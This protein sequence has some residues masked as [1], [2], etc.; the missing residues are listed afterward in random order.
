MS[1]AE[2]QRFAAAVQA[3]PA[4]AEAYRAA[5]TPVELAARLRADGYVVTDA[6]VEEVHRSGAELSDEQLDDVSGGV[7]AAALASI[8]GIGAIGVL[9]G[10]IIGIV[11]A[12]AKRGT[13]P[14]G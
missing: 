13:L 5:A 7:V 12:A 3:T 10:A 1:Q 6:E 8:V 9:A 2:L 11:A 14:K 4:L